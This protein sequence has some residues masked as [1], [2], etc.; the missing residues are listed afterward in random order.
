MKRKNKKNPSALYQS[1]TINV[2]T[3]VFAS[4][5]RYYDAKW[6]VIILNFLPA[7]N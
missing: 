2:K 6:I 4:N 5:D 3:V 1:K 7:T